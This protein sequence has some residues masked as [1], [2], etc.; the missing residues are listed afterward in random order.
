MPKVDGYG[1]VEA[2]KE[3]ARTTPLLIYTC[4]DLSAADRDLLTLG[5]TRHLTKGTASQLDLAMV[6]HE[7]LG[8]VTKSHVGQTID[9]SYT[10]SGNSSQDR[11]AS[12]NRE[13]VGRKAI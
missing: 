1:V 7:L 9:A 11:V 5:V 3:E 13:P 8:K 2:L 10:V 4:S 12:L 6:V